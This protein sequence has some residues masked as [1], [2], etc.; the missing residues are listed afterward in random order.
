MRTVARAWALTTIRGGAGGGLAAVIRAKAKGPTI[1][2]AI[3]SGGRFGKWR[4]Y[5][6]PGMGPTGAIAPLWGLC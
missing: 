3:R 5:H 4:V 2:M 1:V 6:C